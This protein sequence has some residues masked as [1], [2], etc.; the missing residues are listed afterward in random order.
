MLSAS[1][2]GILQLQLCVCV[3]SLFCWHILD[4]QKAS[5]KYTPEDWDTTDLLDLLC[6]LLNVSRQT[7]LPLVY[8]PQCAEV[9]KFIQACK[10]RYVK[11][12]RRAH[13]VPAAEM[14]YY[15]TDDKCNV[16]CIFAKAGDDA[17]L[18]SLELLDEIRDQQP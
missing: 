1:E 3:F 12:G 4:C 5:I 13:D 11:F 8:A 18:I 2:Y 10:V 15:T 17:I 14:G 6:F 7:V 16:L 9:G